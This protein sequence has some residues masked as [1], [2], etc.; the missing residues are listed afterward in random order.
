MAYEATNKLTTDQLNAL[1]TFANA[2]GRTWKAN[3]RQ[4]WM[5]GRYD[6]YAGVER[7]DLLQQIRN[8]F[9]PSWLVKFKGDTYEP[10]PDTTT[11]YKQ[12]YRLTLTDSQGVVI[13]AW[14]LREEVDTPDMSEVNEAI[15]RAEVK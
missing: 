6:D 15:Q 1:R 4:A 2:N 9:G 11:T 14:F 12:S 8:Q 10:Q 5:T 3:L 13:D 7:S